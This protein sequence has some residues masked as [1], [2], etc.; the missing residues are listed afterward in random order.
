[1]DAGRPHRRLLDPE[2]R[3]QGAAESEEREDN[4]NAPRYT[5]E[6]DAH[7]YV[8]HKRFEI[9]EPDEVGIGRVMRAIYRMVFEMLRRGTKWGVEVQIRYLNLITWK[10]MCALNAHCGDLEKQAQWHGRKLGKDSWRHL[11]IAGYRQDSITVPNFTGDGFIVLGG[12]SRELTRREFS[13]VMQLIEEWGRDQ[14]P[15]IQW[16]DPN[17]KS[18][19]EAEARRAA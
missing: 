5:V 17:W 7:G 16:S 6:H 12:S 13:D 2:D 10:Q 18:L 8:K 1:M 14:N 11:F 19:Q 15:P 9:F 3:G 4:V